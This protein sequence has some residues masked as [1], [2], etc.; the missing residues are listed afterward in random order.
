MTRSLVVPLAAALGSLLL[1]ACGARPTAAQ[2]PHSTV[3]PDRASPP[4]P[5]AAP[6]ITRL[7]FGGWPGSNTHQWGTRYLELRASGDRDPTTM[8]RIHDEIDFQGSGMSPSDM[9]PTRHV[10]TRWELLPA[11]IT[12][13]ASMTPRSNCS[14]DAK[15]V[16]D[17]I[18][19]WFNA[20]QP[21][22]PATSPDP[23]HATPPAGTTY[24][25]S[26]VGC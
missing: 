16:C 5:V 13:P 26:L 1:G 3:A 24:G 17:E 21:A 4:E 18:R 10:C 8:I 14:G 23:K 25:R 7:A 12:I 20:T 19:T 9:G 22:L 6:L 15:A 11:A 2:P